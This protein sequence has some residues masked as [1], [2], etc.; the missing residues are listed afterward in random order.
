M[1][2]ARNSR[3]MKFPRPCAVKKRPPAQRVEKMIDKDAKGAASR[4]ME[5]LIGNGFVM[6]RSKNTAENYTQ[7]K[8]R[9]DSIAVAEFTKTE[10]FKNILKLR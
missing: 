10:V 1:E 4:F 2:A 3:F 7:K 8:Q 6:S 9:R 5:K